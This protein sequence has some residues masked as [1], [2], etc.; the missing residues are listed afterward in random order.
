[1]IYQID[2]INLKTGAKQ[3]N[4]QF[5]THLHIQQ[6]RARAL[7]LA[8][9]YQSVE[10][11]NSTD[12]KNALLATAIQITIRSL[13]IHSNLET[14]HHQRTLENYPHRHYQVT[15]QETPTLASHLGSLGYIAADSN[16]QLDTLEAL[17]AIVN[18]FYLHHSIDIR[19]LPKAQYENMLAVL[20]FAEAK[21]YIVQL[22]T[23]LTRAAQ[24]NHPLLIAYSISAEDCVGLYS[25]FL[26]G[27]FSENLPILIEYFQTLSNLLGGEL[28]TLEPNY[29]YKL[30]RKTYAFGYSAGPRLFWHAALVNNMLKLYKATPDNVPLNQT[31]T[32]N[33]LQYLVAATDAFYMLYKHNLADYVEPYYL[34]YKALTRGW[35]A[36]LNYELPAESR[37]TED[38]YLTYIPSTAS[39]NPPGGLK[40]LLSTNSRSVNNYI[41][42]KLLILTRDYLEVSLYVEPLESSAV[43]FIQRLVRVDINNLEFQ[44]ALEGYGEG[45]IV[46]KDLTGKVISNTLVF[47]NNPTDLRP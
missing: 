41:D 32:K 31:I 23:L 38:N 37:F 35:L 36:A 24:N 26:Y 10:M 3:S 1:M 27:T 39:V 21:N 45:I 33:T 28:P 8:R 20:G 42:I 43:E 46:V 2:P 11:E 40:V 19:E 4:S 18:T 44:L 22:E 6:S 14:R 34:R 17:T 25:K 12:F 30:L 47:E 5:R 13:A 15:L 16:L 9:Q 7:K 29:I